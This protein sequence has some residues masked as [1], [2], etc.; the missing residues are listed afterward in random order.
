MPINK[1]FEAA[2][3]A[4]SENQPEVKKSYVLQRSLG[5]LGSLRLLSS[6][7]ITEELIM[8]CGDH[9]VTVRLYYPDMDKKKDRKLIIFFHGGGWVVGNINSY[10]KVCDT[11]AKKTDC[12][13]ASVDYRLAP[14]NKFPAGLEDCYNAAKHFFENSNELFGIAPDKITIMGD[15]AGGNLS[16]AVCLMARDR[17]EF[18]PKSQILLYPATYNDHSESSPFESIRTKGKDYVLTAER[19]CEYMELYQSKEED[20]ESPYFAPYIAEDLSNQPA[21]LII[22][23]EYDP[24]RDE[25]EAYGEKLREA[26]NSVAVYR[27][28][29]ALHGF[30]SFPDFIPTVKKTYNM[31]VR[32]LDE[33][34]KTEDKTPEKMDEA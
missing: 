24:L 23:A 20:K 32:F 13:V 22:T 1:A 16:A 10:N 12:K 34:E 9:D 11:I 4:I 5:N 21:T 19:I 3:K 27:V 7:F 2:L 18:K 6:R 30:M 33:L 17:G 25:G 28:E 15:S 31:I 14:E 8:N 29:N 26:G